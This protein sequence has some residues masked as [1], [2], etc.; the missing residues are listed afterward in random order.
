MKTH[1]GS[2]AKKFRNSGKARV[3]LIQRLRTELLTVELPLEYQRT[4]EFG[5]V[6]APLHHESC[7]LPLRG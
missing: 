1:E 4:T 7:S 5:F 3:V 6:T 2:S